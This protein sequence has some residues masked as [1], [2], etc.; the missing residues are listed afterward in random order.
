MYGDQ[1]NLFKSSWAVNEGFSSLYDK[2]IA[3]VP[4]EGKY[5][6]ADLRINIWS[7]FVLPATCCMICLIMA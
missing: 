3:R 4:F 2:L 5:H 6:R 7:A 1:L